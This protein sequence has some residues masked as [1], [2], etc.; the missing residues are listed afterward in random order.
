MAR[1]AAPREAL[2]GARADA[3]ERLVA[4]MAAHPELVAG[5]GRA[6]TGIMRAVNRGGEIRAVV[7]TGAEGVFTAIL[8]GLKLGVALKIDDGATRAS[9]SAIAALLVRL[10]V[11]EA[12]HPEIRARMAPPQRNRR[13]IVTGDI[14]PTFD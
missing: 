10:G 1:M 8:P 2:T 5:E 14:R 11:A 4:A 6:C 7:K 12:D 13:G 3:A 9:E